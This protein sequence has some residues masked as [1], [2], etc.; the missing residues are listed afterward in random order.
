MV[1]YADD[2]NILFVDKDE[3][4][5]HDKRTLLMTCLEI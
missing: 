3:N 2:I 1:L 5:L 4:V